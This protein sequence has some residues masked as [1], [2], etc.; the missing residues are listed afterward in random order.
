MMEQE[1][2]YSNYSLFVGD[3]AQF[4]SEIELKALFSTYGE[5]SE[6]RI[7]RNSTTKK[8]L[9]YGFVTFVTTDGASD[10]LK[11]LNNTPFHGRNL[12]YI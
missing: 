8:P 6:V 9:C 4:C 11:S 12:R 3:L 7:M 2:I 5:V 10:A 1:Q